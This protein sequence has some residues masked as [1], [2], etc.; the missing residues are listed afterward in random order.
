MLLTWSC[1]YPPPW[2]D[3]S[4]VNSFLCGGSGV[5]KWTRAAPNYIKSHLGSEH[6]NGQWRPC[7]KFS[8]LLD[9][10]RGL[11]FWGHVGRWIPDTTNLAAEKR[12]L[13]RIEFTVLQQHDNKGWRKIYTE[14][15]SQGWGL[16]RHSRRLSWFTDL[17]TQS[18]K[19]LK[20][21]HKTTEANRPGLVEPRPWLK[22]LSAS[23]RGTCLYLLRMLNLAWTRRNDINPHFQNLQTSNQ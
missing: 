6:H 12:P 11:R 22:A 5:R 10:R 7:V 1:S 9:H 21:W 20:L 3:C 17:S 19:T 2:V 23:V 8:A 18:Q 13:R 4:L 14:N 15:T 16:E